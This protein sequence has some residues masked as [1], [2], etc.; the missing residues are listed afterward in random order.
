MTRN[1]LRPSPFP[2]RTIQGG[3][4]GGGAPARPKALG[5]T[6]LRM[7]P[8]ELAAEMAE[9]YAMAL[10]RDVPFDQLSSPHARVRIDPQTEFSLHELLCELRSLAWFDRHALPVGFAHTA[11][12]AHRALRKEEGHRRSARWNGDGQLTLSTLLRG[13]LPGSAL[14]SERGHGAFLS[15][16]MAP[17]VPDGAPPLAEALGAMPGNDRPLDDWAGWLAALT[18]ARTA[19]PHWPEQETASALPDLR[20]LAGHVH[21]HHPSQ[22]LF[23]AALHLLAHGVPRDPHLGQPGLWTG[24]HIL[25]L[26]AEVTSRSLRASRELAAAPLRMARPGVIAARLSMLHNR[27]EG[28]N[29]GAVPDAALEP[30]LA[31]VQAALDELTQNAPNLL[32]WIGRLNRRDGAVG[33]GRAMPGPD[34]SDTRFRDNLML[35]GTMVDNVPLMPADGAG[36]AIVAGACATLLKALFATHEA[37]GQPVTLGTTAPRAVGPAGAAQNGNCPP[38]PLLGCELDKLA[39]N[40]ALGRNL[41]GGFWHAETRAS[42]RLG[43]RLALGLVQERLVAAARPASVSLDD[44]AGRRVVAGVVAGAGAAVLPSLT[45]DGCPRPIC[46]AE[47]TGLRHLTA[48]V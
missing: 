18:Q 8:S 33:F 22:A 20:A 44:F 39:G 42:L 12:T 45:I 19:W 10:L 6:P 14:T 25:S 48:V 15:R 16:L 29:E 3:R 27:S 5:V 37:D 31:L 40:V 46:R 43:E 9:L 13:A 28:R 17:R 1:L 11:D 36:H 35:P 34:W 41:A 30:E 21:L 47:E 2:F 23:H 26:M 38:R 4:R 24:P 32:R 7:G